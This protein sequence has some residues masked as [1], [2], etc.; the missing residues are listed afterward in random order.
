MRLAYKF[1]QDFDF[2]KQQIVNDCGRHIEELQEEHREH[3]RNI[4]KKLSSDQRKVFII[5]CKKKSSNAILIKNFWKQNIFA[6]AET[7]KLAAEVA[8]LT[9]QKRDLTYENSLLRIRLKAKRAPREILISGNFVTAMQQKAIPGL[10][11]PYFNPC[12]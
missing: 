4:E 3:I 1:E 9:K 8:E 5:I 11:F 10:K 2:H 6:A 7:K 12:G